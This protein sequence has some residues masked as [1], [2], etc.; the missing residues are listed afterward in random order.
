MWTEIMLEESY[1]VPDFR[2]I[3]KNVSSIF[4]LEQMFD[5]GIKK[6]NCG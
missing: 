1:P 3:T 6:K 4:H 2:N 5:L